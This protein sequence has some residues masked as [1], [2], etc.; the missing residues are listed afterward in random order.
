PAPGLPDAAGDPLRELDI[1]GV[2]V[3]VPG[4]EERTGADGD[5]SGGGVHP[6]PAEVRLAAVLGDLGLQALVLPAT[7]VGELHPIGPP[8]RPGVQVD[9][10]VEALGDTGAEAAGELDGLV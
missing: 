10:Q 3:D 2:E 6:G 1:L 8:R 4:N 5:R 9:R 7:D